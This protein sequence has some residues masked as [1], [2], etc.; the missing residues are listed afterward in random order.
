MTPAPS[1]PQAAEEAFYRAFEHGDL[2]AMMAVW[3]PDGPVV[4]IHPGGT[5]LQGRDAIRAS[6]SRIFA[7]EGRFTFSLSSIQVLAA[8]D[9][10]AIHSLEEHIAVGGQ[11]QGIVLAT[12]VYR[13][14]AGAWY[15]ASHHGSPLP[16]QRREPQPSRPLH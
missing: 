8:S 6:W 12:N 13:Q 3:A 7:A 16:Q 9:E 10:L 5:R 15:V 4:C 14:Q 11:R 1:S 2:E